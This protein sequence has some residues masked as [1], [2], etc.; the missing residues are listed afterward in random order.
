[1]ADGVDLELLAAGYHH[2]P[3][4]PAALARAA[5]LWREADAAPGD[6]GVDVGGGRGGL[7]AGW[8]EAGGLAVVVDPS[9][10]MLAEAPAGVLAVGGRAERL[11]LPDGVARVVLFHMSLHHTAWPTA[12]AEAARVLASGGRL[13]IWTMHPDDARHTFMARWFPSVPEIEARRFPHPDALREALEAVGLKV[14]EIGREQEPVLRTAGEWRAAVDARFISTL[15]LL[16]PAE[17]AEGLAAFDAAHPDPATPV[18]YER[19][20]T[21]VLASRPREAPKAPP[22]ERHEPAKMSVQGRSPDPA[23]MDW[24]AARSI[25]CG[26]RDRHG[27][28]RQTGTSHSRL[29][30]SPR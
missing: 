13:G 19:R 1:M 29:A 16:H 2:R 4:T 6:L 18:E 3:D 5:R 10:G 11:P 17:L 28:Q 23:G 14:V 21:R 26:S 27:P 12:L 25:S 7:A 30:A 8:V 24:S 9:A 22:A 15:Q 20:F